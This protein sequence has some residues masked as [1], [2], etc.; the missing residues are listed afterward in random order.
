M[1]KASLTSFFTNMDDPLSVTSDR[2][3]LCEMCISV[4]KYAILLANHPS[5]NTEETTVATHGCSTYT[6]QR[7]DDCI[8]LTHALMKDF[9]PS[10]ALF[11][12]AELQLDVEDLRTLIVSKADQRCAELSCCG[13]KL[14]RRHSYPQTNGALQPEDIDAEARVLA[15]QEMDLVNQRA[16]ILKQKMSLDDHISRLHHDAKLLEKTKAS[17]RQRRL[18]LEALE[19]RLR[20]R[21]QRITEK[22]QDLAER[23]KLT[24]YYIPYPMNIGGPANFA[25]YP[26][27]GGASATSAPPSTTASS[28]L[29]QGTSPASTLS[30]TTTT[31]TQQAPTPRHS[32]S[33]DDGVVPGEDV[34]PSDFDERDEANSFMALLQGLRSSTPDNEI[35]LDP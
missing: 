5:E 34:D 8:T 24:P 11:T 17:I 23:Q 31:P 4:N 1:L 29:E 27:A 12:T 15:K 20:H 7:E 6:S 30:T 9:E 16:E 10:D 28:S 26:P 2:V 13:S 18:A 25:P 32:S 33:T 22:E 3:A 21:E 19:R 14:F 35:S